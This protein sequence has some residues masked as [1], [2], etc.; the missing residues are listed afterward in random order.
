M[1]SSSSTIFVFKSTRGPIELDEGRRDAELTKAHNTAKNG[2]SPLDIRKEKAAL[3]IHKT[4]LEELLFADRR[5]KYFTKANKL[6]ASGQSTTRIRRTIPAGPREHED[7][8]MEA[9]VKSWTED[10]TSGI[11]IEDRWKTTMDWLVYY[12][13]GTWRKLA[14]TRN[15]SGSFRDFHLFPVP[16]NIP[17]TIFSHQTLQEVAPAQG[18]FQRCIPM[19]RVLA[20]GGGGSYYFG[21]SHWSNHVNQAHGKMNAPQLDLEPLVTQRPT[22]PSASPESDSTRQWCQKEERKQRWRS[23]L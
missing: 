19:S 2:G 23:R 11:P 17:T 12:M 15:H 14:T 21:S 22:E 6:R 7:L 5:A 18:G 13:N 16:E 10:V 1:S 9:V 3:E 8:D 20:I 4:K